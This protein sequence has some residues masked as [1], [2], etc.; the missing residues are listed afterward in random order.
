MSRCHSIAGHPCRNVLQY[1]NKVSLVNCSGKHTVQKYNYKQKATYFNKV[2]SGALNVES[3]QSGWTAWEFVLYCNAIFGWMGSPSFV[4]WCVSPSYLLPLCSH[5]QLLF[6]RL[7][8]EVI[9]IVLDSFT[10][11]LTEAF[12]LYLWKFNRFESSVKKKQSNNSVRKKYHFFAEEAN[13]K[14]AEK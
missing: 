6:S 9:A 4:F 2:T 8:Y 3:N 5:F 1:K 7:F 11:N 12:A 14:N 10:L 13:V